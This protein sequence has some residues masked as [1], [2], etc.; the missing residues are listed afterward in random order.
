MYRRTVLSVLLGVALAA[1]LLAARP[2]AALK[3]GTD[4][5]NT[6]AANAVVRIAGCTGTLIEPDLVLTAGHCVNHGPPDDETP[7]FNE[8]DW[9]VPG[10]WYDAPGGLEAVVGHDRS[11]VS[12]RGTR[13]GTSW[14]GF[15]L[16]NRDRYYLQHGDAINLRTSGGF[17]LVAED[18]GGTFVGADRKRARSWE[19][20]E[21]RKVSG[22]YRYIRDGDAVSLRAS[23]GQYVV[24]E[25][26]GGGHVNANRDWVRSWETFRIRNLSGG[27]YIHD[28]DEVSLETADG[29]HFVT[30]H[31]GGGGG[32]RVSVTKYTIP[33]HAD[34]ILFRLERDVPWYRA[35]PAR[36]L[37]SPPPASL[38]DPAAFW[39]RQ[40]FQ[41]VGWGRTGG[42]TPRYRQVAQAERGYFCN[43]YGWSWSGKLCVEGIDG[44][45]VRP[46]DS[47]G[48][49]FWVDPATGRRYLIAVAQ[50]TENPDGG[51]Y[52]TTFAQG[53]RDS[54]GDPKP[55][56]GIWL[57]EQLGREDC[58]GFDPDD[59]SI[60]YRSG[61]KLVD[62]SVRLEHFS[63]YADA[64]RARDVVRHYRL[65]HLCF[66]DRPGARMSYY[67]TESR[68]APV[69]GVAGEDAVRFDPGALEISRFWGH[70]ILK[71]ED[72][73]LLSFGADP[74]G[75][76]N[77]ASFGESV[78][79]R[80]GFDHMVLVGGRTGMMYFRR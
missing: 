12:A 52:M 72:T 27:T 2:A 47:G 29:S 9:E 24:A 73:Y 13:P 26:G 75:D 22:S 53:G 4:D 19:T 28:G 20:F 34:M 69:G 36:V 67:L 63:S 54:D 18:G 55:D 7:W 71:D 31:Y 10:R 60:I 61:W 80:Y 70:W 11:G 23:N 8:F 40:R 68:E 35:T 58:I 48:P 14:T 39:G 79:E 43:T 62:G 56:T 45:Q 50:G 5:R 16:K 37:T 3:N 25:G 44:A 17:F 76:Y 65:G 15:T 38:D 6:R 74:I 51:R 33:S 46:G 59:V 21:I 1:T 57:D 41:M 49:L 64:E 66:V 32:Y 42:P 77:A 30:V 78:I